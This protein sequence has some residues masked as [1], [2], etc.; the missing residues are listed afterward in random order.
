MPSILP[1][2]AEKRRDTSIGALQATAEDQQPVETLGA[3]GTHEPLR[4]GVGL[5]RPDR[6][7]DDRDALAA[8]DLVE[9]G[10]ELAVAV[11]DQ[12]PCPLEPVREAEVARLL[13]HPGTGRLARAP[14]EVDAA[15][16]ELDEEEHV[17]AA[18]ADRLDGEEIARQHARRLVA[19]KLTPAWPAAPRRRR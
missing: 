13:D 17:V 3:E 11:V 10:A 7:L 2:L 1:A 6:R 14:G 16:S 18:Q 19:K 4:V 12:E 8:K 9:G 5:W 15:A